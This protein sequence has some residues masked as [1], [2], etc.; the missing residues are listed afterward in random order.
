MSKRKSGLLGFVS[1]WQ[2]QT[3]ANQ[4]ASFWASSVMAPNTIR[5]AQ[6]VIAIGS[7]SKFWRLMGGS[8][9]VFGARIGT[10]GRKRN[11]GKSKRP[12]RRLKK[13]GKSVMSKACYA[14]MQ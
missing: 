13:N 2:Y 9:I 5:P 3:L 8:F 6:P 14:H 11:L 10:Y 1:I 12:S 7:A 4:G